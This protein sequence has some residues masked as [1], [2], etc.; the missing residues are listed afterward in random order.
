MNSILMRNI[1]V[2]KYTKIYGCWLI[3]VQTANW[4]VDVHGKWK[5]DKMYDLM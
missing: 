3:G 5:H 4:S 2:K 1:G